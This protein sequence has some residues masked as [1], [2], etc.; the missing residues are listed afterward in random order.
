M[1]KEGT[2]G[3]VYMN[4]LKGQEMIYHTDKKYYIVIANIQRQFRYFY[5]HNITRPNN[6]TVLLANC[7]EYMQNSWMPVN[8]IKIFT[9]DVV[10]CI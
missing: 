1:I 3:K 7:Y 10:K 8:N 4:G 2:L 5:T 6:L 9:G